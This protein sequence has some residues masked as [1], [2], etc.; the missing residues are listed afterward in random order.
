MA[1]RDHGEIVRE[2]FLRRQRLAVDGGL[3]E[4]GGE[5]IGGIRALHRRQPVAV[6][7]AISFEMT[8]NISVNLSKD[9]NSHAQSIH[10]A[11]RPSIPK[12]C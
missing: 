11:A 4:K 2:Q 7:E 10:K 3:H 8:R 9:M 1:G 5:V 6:V 12:I